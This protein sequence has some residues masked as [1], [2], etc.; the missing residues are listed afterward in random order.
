MRA[1]S[2]VVIGLLVGVAIVPVESSEKRVILRDHPRLRRMVTLEERR[3][4]LGALKTVS[5]QGAQPG[6]ISVEID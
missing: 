5:V 2:C 4:E 6:L 3:I 1:L